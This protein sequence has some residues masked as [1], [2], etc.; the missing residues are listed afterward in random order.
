MAIVSKNKETSPE[1]ARLLNL[2]LKNIKQYDLY[3]RNL[4]EIT[5]F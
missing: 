2:C 3:Q 5:T 1:S 4:K